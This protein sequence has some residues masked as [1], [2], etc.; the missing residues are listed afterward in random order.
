M[1]PANRNERFPSA[2]PVRP[3][4]RLMERVHHYFDQHPEVSRGE[5]L[6]AA[7]QREI[8]FREQQEAHSRTRPVRPED[9]GPNSWSSIGRPPTA[10][11]IRIHV[12][13]CKR[14]AALHYE[15]HGLW[16]KLRR[17]LFGNRLV[18]WLGLQRGRTE[19]PK[20]RTIPVS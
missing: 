4:H 17:F 1:V 8:H 16:P 3:D 6:L 10:E 18:A 2:K 20:G 7:L 11:D 19:Q 14:M 15:R 13:L 9:Q 5:L 12:W